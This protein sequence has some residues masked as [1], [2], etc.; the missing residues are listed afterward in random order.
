[1]DCGDVREALSS[2]LDGEPTPEP[3]TE[4]AEHVRACRACRQFLGRARELDALT[5]ST[6]DFPD[7]TGAVL[8]TART[9]SGPRPFAIWASSLRLGLVGVG[10]AQLALAVPGLLFGSDEGAPL[11]VA[12]EVGAWDL[13]LAVGFVYAAWRP[14]RALGLLPFAAALS[15]GLLLT[16]V[17]DVAHGRAVALT[18][19]THLLE[20]LGT[21]LL[22]LLVAPRV[23][24]GTKVGLRVV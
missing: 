9:G 3:T 6:E 10:I 1:M 18:E 15:A 13:A 5:R 2:L 4:L 24:P 7:V 23:G 17:I 12:H 14:L 8:D 11:H 16:A 21:A 19:T 22:Y 20:L